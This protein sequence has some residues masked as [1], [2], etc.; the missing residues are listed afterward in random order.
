[1]RQKSLKFG[2]FRQN[3]ESSC[4][5]CSCYSVSDLFKICASNQQLPSLKHYSYPQT[6]CSLDV[7]QPSINHLG[8]LVKHSEQLQGVFK[9]CKDS[10]EQSKSQ[11]QQ[12]QID[13]EVNRL[14]NQRVEEQMKI[15]NPTPQTD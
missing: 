6:E 9:D 3:S 8:S 13:A 14:V 4:K 15:V 11:L 12:Q 2:S 7:Q 1:M 5:E 10:I